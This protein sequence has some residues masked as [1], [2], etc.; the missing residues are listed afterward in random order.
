[1]SG[2]GIGEQHRI[3]QVLRQPVGVAHCNHF[4]L[5]TVH[6]KRWLVDTLQVRK[7]LAPG[8]LPFTKRGQLGSC[9]LRSRRR[10]SI[11]RMQQKLVEECLP[12]CL[13]C[14]G[15]SEED[16]L[17]NCIALEVGVKR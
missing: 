15:R 3:G 9:D 17:Q 2:A 8:L 4:V 16:L 6:H 5:N 10:V 11:L 13:A 12:S 1:M 7:A 14:R